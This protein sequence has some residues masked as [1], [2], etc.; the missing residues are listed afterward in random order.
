VYSLNNVARTFADALFAHVVEDQ[1]IPLIDRMRMHELTDFLAIQRYSFLTP[2]AANALDHSESGNYYDRSRRAKLNKPIKIY[3]NVNPG[4]FNCISKIWDCLL[5]LD[6][7]D[8][9]DIL[10]D[11][12]TKKLP[13]AHGTTFKVSYESAEFNEDDVRKR[14]EFKIRKDFIVKGNTSILK[15][16]CTVSKFVQSSRGPPL[17]IEIYHSSLIIDRILEDHYHFFKI[18]SL[19]FTSNL[20]GDLTLA[21][22]EDTIYLTLEEL[23]DIFY[24]GVS[25]DLWN[26]LH[27]QVKKIISMKLIATIF[28]IIGLIFNYRANHIPRA[29]DNF[30]KSHLGDLRLEGTTTPGSLLGGKN[31]KQLN[32]PK[33]PSV[34]PKKP[35]VKPKKPSVKPKKPA[36]M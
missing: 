22:I 19:H 15:M 27:E 11:G 3:Q 8:F 29:V 21:D 2:T 36:N 14:L 4:T 24:F 1:V 6:G 32:K 34:K 23:C 31:I 12:F 18:S 35:T 33:K 16:F 17:P 28:K 26:P 20:K 7:R 30:V 9:P 5:G 25:S 10:G 13:S